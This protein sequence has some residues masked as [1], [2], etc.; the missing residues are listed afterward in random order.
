[1][2]KALEVFQTALEFYGD[3]EEQVEKAEAVF[4]A[5]AKMETQLK[6]YDRARV[7]Y[8]VCVF[9]DLDSSTQQLIIIHS[10]LHRVYLDPSPQAHMS[11]TQIRKATRHTDYA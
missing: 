2:D 10:L 1:V 4:S 11:H 9:G 3:K 8:K 5:F 7:I 6:E